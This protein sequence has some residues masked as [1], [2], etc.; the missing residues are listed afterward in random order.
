MVKKF[1]ICGLG[2]IGQR[3]Y[4]NLRSLGHNPAVFRKGGGANSDFIEKFLKEESLAGRSVRIY[5]D[6]DEAMNSFDPDAVFITNPNSCHLD[7]ALKAARFK[8]HLFIEKPLSNNLSGMDELKSLANQNN[9]HVM[10]AYN[11]RW[12][13]LLV[14]MKSLV[15]SGKIGKPISAHIE[16]GECIEDWHPWEDYRKTYAAH[17]SG[18]GGAVLCFSHDIDY[19]YWFFGKPKK[20]LSIGGKITPLE[21]DAEDM[22][23]ALLEY[24]NNM[25]VSLHLDYWQRPQKRSFEIIG[26]KGRIIWD[27][28]AKNLVEYPREKGAKPV[29]YKIPEGFDRN[30]MFMDEV[31]DFIL[32]LDG[33]IKVPIPL[34]EGIDVLEMSIEIK[35]GI[36]F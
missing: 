15:E 28:C 5:H 4:K 3:H 19:L 32:A 25:I 23:K 13:P 27:Y 8:K 6:F 24:E 26:T 14:K 31:R 21:G 22:V 36:N 2:S 1:L 11:L 10:I 30:D 18:G 17:K 7:T 33:E 16:M 29:E 35:R 34:Q 20:V 9:L 12:H